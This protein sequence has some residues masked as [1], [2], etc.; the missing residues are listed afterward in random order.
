MYEPQGTNLGHTSQ[1]QGFSTSWSSPYLHSGGSASHSSSSL[2]ATSQRVKAFSCPLFSCGRLFK[3]LEHLKRHMRTH[4]MERP[5]QCPICRRRFSRSDNLTQHGRIHTRPSDT[6]TSA[7][8]SGLFGDE[9]SDAD[10]EGLDQLDGDDSDFAAYAS[11]RMV[12]VEVQGELPEEGL[13]P[14]VATGVHGTAHEIFPSSMPNVQFAQPGTREQSYS[15][16]G[17]SSPWCMQ[18]TPLPS[19]GFCSPEASPVQVAQQING[20][21]APYHSYGR[22]AGSYAPVS[23]PPHKSAFDQPSL[24]TQSLEHSQPSG[25]GPIRR[26]RSVTPSLAQNGEV[27]R[28]PITAASMSD[29]R[30][31]SPARGY[32]PY[33]GALASGHAPN[34]STRSSP[35]GYHIPLEP[36][37]LHQSQIPRAVD[38]PMQGSANFAAIA[39]SSMGFGLSNSCDPSSYDGIYMTEASS[40]VPES[41][42]PQTEPFYHGH[43]APDYFTATHGEPQQVV[44]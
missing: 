12:E 41:S 34:S 19:P 24:Y 36:T 42:Y 32:H 44:M 3:R 14:S 6:G 39:T 15:A 27:I 25:S 30:A 37:P 23:A 11:T 26:H 18:T 38:E 21:S 40:S 22:V 8:D 2:P 20:S 28:R 5:F 35:A 13:L 9:E 33:A 16:V 1:P 10:I 29:Y 7:F 43:A 31:A 4:T 17:T